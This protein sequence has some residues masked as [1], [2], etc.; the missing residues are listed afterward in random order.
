MCYI[1]SQQI[2]LVLLRQDKDRA[3]QMSSSLDVSL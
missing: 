1:L 2:Y 3:M